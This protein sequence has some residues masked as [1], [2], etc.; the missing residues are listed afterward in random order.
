[1]N[2]ALEKYIGYALL[3]KKILD[4]YVKLYKMHGIKPLALSRE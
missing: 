2:G 1:V 3:R 4:H